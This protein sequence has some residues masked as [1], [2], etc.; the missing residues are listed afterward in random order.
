MIAMTIG[1]ILL[2]GVTAGYAALGRA[3]ARLAEAQ[4]GLAGE[5]APRCRSEAGEP[6]RCT[7]PEIC[8]YD[9]VDQACRSTSPS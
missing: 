2:V 9:V 7:L 1:S 5:P 6:D 8:E 4:G 3:G